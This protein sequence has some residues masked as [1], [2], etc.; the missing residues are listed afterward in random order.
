MDKLFEV[1]EVRVNLAKRIKEMAQKF[2][3]NKQEW[4]D[5]TEKANWD[6][7]N[8]DYDDNQ[9]E[10]DKLNAA[11]QVA[12]RASE[13]N[14]IQDAKDRIQIDS[15]LPALP[16]PE[17]ADRAFSAWARSQCGIEVSEQDQAEARACGMPTQPGTQL[18]L[19][20]FNQ[21]KWM[22]FRDEFTSVHPTQRKRFYNAPLTS[23]TDATG[24]TTIP[25]GSLV[26]NLEVAMVAFGGMLQVAD[27][28]TTSGGEPL[29]FPTVDDTANSARKVAESTAM[30]DN[31]A[32]GSSGDGG[33]NPTFSAMTLNAYKYTSDT[34][35]VPYEL[36]QD[37]AFDI[38]GLLGR[39]MGERLGRTMNTEFT[40][41]DGTGD[42]NGIITAAATGKTAAAAGDYTAKEIMDL[43]HSVDPAYRGNG[44]FMMHDAQINYIR[45][46]TDAVV[47][48]FLWQPGFQLGVP[49]RILGYPYTVN[50]DMEDETLTGDK[51]MIFGDLSYYKIRR[52]GG[53]RV[54]RLVERYREKDQDGFVA[55]LRADGDLLDSGTDALKMMVLA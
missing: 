7:L 41:G 52:V 53:V 22:A 55:V 16:S 26:N 28:I 24:A 2:Q 43:V 47:G 19:P 54:Y 44:Q 30:D 14:R 8:T 46:L 20:L 35:L 10:L 38:P 40:N 34:I 6:Q 1:N 9:K 23:T 48:Q 12:A 33:P 42:A 5:E 27:V 3:D 15:G 32:S 29:E 4:V 49:D 18:N 37:S 36:L 25:P 39:L 17:M 11:A 13:L 31:A 51:V 45:Q 50:Q 21:R